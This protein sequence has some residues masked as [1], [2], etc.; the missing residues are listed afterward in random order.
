[1]APFVSIRP[2]LGPL[3]LPRRSVPVCARGDTPAVPSKTQGCEK[4][5]PDSWVTPL[6]HTQMRD[7]EVVV[8]VVARLR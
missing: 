7:V 8:G 3:T 4:R 2:L 6:H 1:M 5:D